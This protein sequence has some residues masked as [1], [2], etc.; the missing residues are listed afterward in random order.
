MGM[1]FSHYK[2][3]RAAQQ[4]KQWNLNLIDIDAH[5]SKIW[6]EFGKNLQEHI[7]NIL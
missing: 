7:N 5:K 6:K 3:F 1:G 2:G 4:T